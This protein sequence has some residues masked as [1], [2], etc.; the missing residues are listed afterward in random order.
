MAAKLKSFFSLSPVIGIL[1]FV[2]LYL[3][4]TLYYPGGSQ[5]DLHSLGFSWANN[6]WCNLLNENA[7]NGMANP[8]R[9]IAITAMIVLCLS[10][11]IFWYYFPKQVGF[12]KAAR[13][14]IQISAA[15][16]M[17]LVILIFTN[18][19]DSLITAASLIGIIPLT[20][21]YLAL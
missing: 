15:V 21:T 4:A 10:L 5:A 19:H 16:S 13:L 17:I 2:G 6:Y 12:E 14:A 18:L 3:V 20:G 11:I 1:T 8:A 7:M 9:P